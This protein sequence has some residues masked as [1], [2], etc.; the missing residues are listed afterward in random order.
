MRIAILVLRVLSRLP[1]PVLYLLADTLFLLLYYVA[2]YER[3]L[4]YGN[5]RRAFPEKSVKEIAAI[6][7]QSYRN[8]AMVLA[9]VI[10]SITMSRAELAQ[11]VRFAN[12]E[13][14]DG[15][16]AQGQSV[17]ALAA[18][19]CNWEWL[20]LASSITLPVQLDAL[21][22]P[23]KRREFDRLLFTSRT[24]FGACLIPAKDS[25]I[26]IMRRRDRQRLIALVADQG[27]HRDE[28]KYWSRFLHQETAFYQGV[29]KI[30][31][32]TRLPVVF[33]G[34][35]RIKRGH[36]EITLEPLAAPPYAGT[37]HLVMERYIQA[38]ESQVRSSPADWLWIYR[39]W[40]YKRPLY[41]A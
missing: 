5:L 38:V 14:L 18:H 25:I 31:L 17:I 37:A 2:R 11:R 21:Y 19:H 36:Y 41:T 26:E 7:R 10:K 15:Y 23:I 40:K 8:L 3:R 4:V 22:K 39:R 12:V 29:E 24:R 6:A 33:I 30:A 28:E 32:I 35:R 20:L 27:P 9:E 13:V 1:L 16:L 34:M